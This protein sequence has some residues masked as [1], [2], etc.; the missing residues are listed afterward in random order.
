MTRSSNVPGLTLGASRGNG[1]HA[2]LPSQ[3]EDGPDDAD[4]KDDVDDAGN[5]DDAVNGCRCITTGV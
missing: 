4:D 5:A 2:F 3:Q 1:T